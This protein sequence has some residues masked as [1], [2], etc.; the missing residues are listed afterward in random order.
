MFTQL[1]G[2]LGI[3]KLNL[4]R[5]DDIMNCDYLLLKNVMDAKEKLNWIGNRILEGMR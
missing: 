1:L 5:M 4:N 3:Q 2:M